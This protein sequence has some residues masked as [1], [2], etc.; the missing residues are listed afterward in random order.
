MRLC[1]FADGRNVHVRRLA[2]GLAGLGHHVHI[3]SHKPVPVAGVAVERFEIPGPSLRDP[4]RWTARK[5]RYLRG[6]LRRFD[7][8]IVFFLQDYGFTPE[9]VEVGCLVASPRGSDVVTPPGEAP[10]C[11]EL[12][13]SRIA[14]I[15]SAAAVGVAGPHFANVVAKFAGVPLDGIERL[16]LGVDTTVFQPIDKKDRC[17]AGP[18]VGFLKGFREVYGAV[19]VVRAIPGIAARHPQARFDLVG[20]GQ[21]LPQCREIAAELGVEQR[22]R[23]VEAV[24]HG[25]VPELLGL[26]DVSVMPSR[27][28]S[29]GVAAL[30]SSAMRVPVVASDVC[31]FR[32][33]V[34]DG[35]TGELIESGN[36]AALGEA[37]CRLLDDAEERRRLGVAGRRF[38]QQH[39]EWRGVLKQWELVLHA[40]RDRVAVMV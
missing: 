15:R 9:L 20:G 29:F 30:E 7:A 33:T 12:R 21:T 22:I 38:V 18:R 28:E 31:G 3:V 40:A 23:W 26:W 8:V 27:C 37:V 1:F 4:F 13:E 2:P 24:E 32:D 16:P 36:P 39:Y 11:E 17:A 34:L 25:R 14:L 5:A 19:D 6:F 10:P 35:E